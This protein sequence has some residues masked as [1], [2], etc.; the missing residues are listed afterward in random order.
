M[1]IDPAD[2]RCPEC[3]GPV[4]ATPVYCMHCG[5]DLVADSPD[6]A[7]V[8]DADDFGREGGAPSD[9][10]DVGHDGLLDPDGTIDDSL[11]VVVGVLGGGVVGLLTF[12]LFG[13]ATASAWSL[14]LGFIAGL[15][16]TVHLIRRRSVGDAIA[17]A[18]Y[19]IALL[20]FV[21]PVVLFGSAVEGSSLGERTAVAVVGFVITGTVAA[22][23]AV[24][25]HVIGYLAG[26]SN[27]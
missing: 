9:S 20:V 2:P 14:F 19:G 21:F 4:G 22:A 3:D 7:D 23:I 11:T 25:A 8:T 24:A 1:S 6:S 18:G 12:V 13:L 16:A 5:A 27:H 10:T 26:R 17:R 15:G